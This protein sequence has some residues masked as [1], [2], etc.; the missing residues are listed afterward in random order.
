MLQQIKHVNSILRNLRQAFF[1][2][3]WISQ[4]GSFL[5]KIDVQIMNQFMLFYLAKT[6]FDLMIKQ[7]DVL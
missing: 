5:K 2:A 4:N 3:C 1:V 6:I 7:F